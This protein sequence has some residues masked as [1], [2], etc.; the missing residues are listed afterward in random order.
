M[1]FVS[2]LN[3][4]VINRIPERKSLYQVGILWFVSNAFDLLKALNYIVLT[5]MAHF[6]ATD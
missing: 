6:I 4:L 1:V 5:A 2:H 3:V